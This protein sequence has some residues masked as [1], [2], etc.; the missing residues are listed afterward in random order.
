MEEVGCVVVYEEE[1]GVITVNKET[2]ESDVLRIEVNAVL[3]LT[4]H[5]Y[6]PSSCCRLP[7]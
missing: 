6:V 3:L 1:K 4:V 2:V 5:L 7:L